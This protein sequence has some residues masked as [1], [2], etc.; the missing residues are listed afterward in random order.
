MNWS[1]SVLPV[2]AQQCVKANAILLPHFLYEVRHWSCENSQEVTLCGPRVSSISGHLS[3]VRSSVIVPG[4]VSQLLM[5]PEGLDNGNPIQFVLFSAFPDGHAQLLA[6]TA[7]CRSYWAIGHHG[8]DWRCN[9]RFWE[10]RRLMPPF[11]SS[12]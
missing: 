2:E 3:S 4:S 9:Y 6:Y 7:M 12:S 10:H 1:R 11:P 5:K 8:M